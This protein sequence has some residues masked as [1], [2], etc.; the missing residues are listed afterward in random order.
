LAAA[1]EGNTGAELAERKPV[2][3]VIQSN[4]I[5]GVLTVLPIIAVWFVI[6]F[7]LALLSSAGAP[8]ASAITDFINTRVPA[9]AP[10]LANTYVQGAVA[11][12]IVLL[13]LNLIGA[14]ASRML[15]IQFISFMEK[16]ISRIPLIQTVYRAAKQLVGVMHQAPGGAARVVLIDFPHPGLK[17]IGLVMRTF[18]DPSSDQEISAVF[19]PTSPNPTSGYLQL[20]PTAKLVLSD[21]TID[22]AMTMIVSGGAVTPEGMS[23]AG[24]LTK[25]DN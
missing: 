4:L 11:V 16:L 20:V 14:A 17:A 24:T 15:G 21:M 22:Q 19:V 5:A 23:L 18:H 2:L 10:V 6:S 1:C 7:L 12:I 8:L 9:L 13:I 3:K 25:A